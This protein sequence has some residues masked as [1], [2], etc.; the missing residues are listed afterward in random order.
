MIK[1]IFLIPTLFFD[2][3]RRGSS[4]SKEEKVQQILNLEA[5]CYIGSALCASSG[6]GIILLSLAGKIPFK[7]PFFISVISGIAFSILAEYFHDQP[8]DPSTVLREVQTFILGSG[9]REGSSFKY[10]GQEYTIV[11]TRGDGACGAHAVLG[12]KNDQGV[13]AYSLSNVRQLYVETLKNTFQDVPLIKE[14]WEKWMIN[15]LKDYLN[16]KG[17]NYSAMVFSDS[18]V[19]EFEKKLA[20]L[21]KHKEKLRQNQVILFQELL[22]DKEVL[23]LLLKNKIEASSPIIYDQMRG[24][25]KDILKL[26]EKKDKT[27]LIQNYQS[28]AQLEVEM[29]K[30]YE[31]FVKE[32]SVLEAYISGVRNS[33][34]Y[35]STDELGLMAYLFNKRLTIFCEKGGCE[36]REEDSTVYPILEEGEEGNEPVAVFHRGMHYSRCEV[37]LI[38][39]KGVSRPDTLDK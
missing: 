16:Q 21:K 33:N 38:C 20:E 22:K 14:K 39:E 19:A 32:T 37:K 3:E 23:E 36:N 6:V 17:G 29:E 13:Y 2:F 24:I 12:T 26:E 9:L 30:S 35:F 1:S 28:Q 11:C 7:K 25:L 27:P 34:Y 8:F 10:Q 15:F 4:S 31:T 18:L 5:W